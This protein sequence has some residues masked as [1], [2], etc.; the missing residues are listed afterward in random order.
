MIDEPSC[1]A[2]PLDRYPSMN[3]LALDLVRGADRAKQ[4]F[5][6]PEPGRSSSGRD[7][8]AAALRESN[9]AWGNQ[10]GD[11]LDDWARGR[12][13]VVIAGQQVGFGGG[14][15]YTLVKLASLL[16]L[17][18]NAARSG[19]R[20]IPLFWMATEDHDFEE[21]ARLTLQLD[22]RLREFRSAAVPAERRPVGDLPVPEDLRSAVVRATSLPSRGWLEPG[23]SFRDSFARLITSVAGGRVVLVDAML[24]ELRREGRSLFSAAASRLD[25]LQGVIGDRSREIEQAGYRVQVTAGEEGRYTLFYEIDSDGSR[26]LIADAE[27]LQRLA[28]ESPERVST[29]ALMRPLLQDLVF[30]PAAFV[31]GPAEVA[32]Y[33]Q[34][35]RAY[36]L[37]GITQPRVL[38]RAHT[39]VLPQR[40]ID[41]VSRHDIA[42]EEWLDSPEMILSRREQQREA[43]LAERIELLKGHF[44]QE[45]DEIR[46][47]ILRAD[48]S[49]T[50]SLN[51]TTRRI[52]YHL[53]VLG[54]RG[55]RV[56][57]RSDQERFAA[58]ERLANA[59]RPNGV[60]QDRVVGWLTYWL[61]WGDRTLDSIVPCAEPGTDRL[62]IIGIT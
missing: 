21:A 11:M 58:V 12:A 39:L 37:L 24:P 40:L 14:P 29:A 53:D 20:V 42:P 57:A 50:R 25:Q 62:N 56:I 8:L 33:A 22:G 44:D 13:R 41:G 23:V 5:V 46:E 15:L 43:E 32:Y 6:Q 45:L 28:E 54:R 38:L 9:A 10:V 1:C 4:F 59:I 7:E 16:N 2:L 30:E 3:P 55:R 27:R 36:E 31:G 17:A 34:L 51:R 19:E 35:G 60:V 26:S 49:M 61:Q 52:D 47:S 48:P 18:R